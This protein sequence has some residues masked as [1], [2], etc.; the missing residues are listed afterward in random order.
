MRFFILCA[1]ALLLAGC[2][3]KPAAK[4]EAKQPAWVISQ[5]AK[6]PE[7]LYLTGRGSGAS[8]TLAADRARADLIKNI[9][10][11]IESTAQSRTKVD[12]QGGYESSFSQQVLSKASRTIEGVEIADRWYDRERD[13]HYALAV[14]DRAQAAARLSGQISQLETQIADRRREAGAEPDTL[15]K[16]GDYQKAVALLQEREAKNAVLAVLD[17][18]HAGGYVHAAALMQER[19]EAQRALKLAVSGDTE[20][21]A[22][23]ASALGKAGFAA[24]AQ[25]E[26]HYV[27]T[28]RLSAETKLQE[29]WHWSTLVLETTLNERAGHARNAWRFE[30]RSSAT[31]AAGALTRAKRALQEK[32]DR[33]LPEYLTNPER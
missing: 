32:L 17:N 10:V 3:A 7:S 12:H 29:G 5:S 19:R 27:L 13:L 8:Q 28:G 21:A 31:D 25:P 22:M 9:E 4:P 30:V 2:A 6:H 20:A 18:S 1:A 24:V 11:T 16:L 15:V 14:L 23:L 33:E 26:A